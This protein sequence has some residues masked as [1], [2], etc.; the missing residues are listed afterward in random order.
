MYGVFYMEKFL[1]NSWVVS[2]ISGI[3]VFFLT[4]FFINIKNRSKYKKQIYDANIMILNHLRGYVVD[5][6]LPKTEV[7]EAVKSSIAREYAVKCE[8]LL[9]VKSICEELVKD[10]IGNIYISNENKKKY[11]EMLQNHLEQ[12]ANIEQHI[13]NS[14]QNFKTKFDYLSAIISLIAGIFTVIG[15][16][17]ATYVD[18]NIKSLEINQMQSII[19]ILLTVIICVVIYIKCRKN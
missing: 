4:N 2:I 15:S 1:S 7:I 9:N 6:G 16:I 5:N 10:I 19:I 13:P 18:N 12:N 3:I 11:I 8:E 14:N 17:V